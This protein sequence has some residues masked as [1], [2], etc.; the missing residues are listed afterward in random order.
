MSVSPEEKIVSHFIQIFVSA[1]DR[2]AHFVFLLLLLFIEVA[3]RITLFSIKRASLSVEIQFRILPS[4][5][6]W[7]GTN[8]IS[9]K[10]I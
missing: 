9:T 3:G 7:V 5:T 10:S 8:G 1:L 2:Y 4:K 6:E